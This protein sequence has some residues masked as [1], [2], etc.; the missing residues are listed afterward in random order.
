[1]SEQNKQFIIIDGSSYL[2]RAYYAL[3]PLTNTAGHPTGAMY[4][5]VN[6]IKKL[7]KQYKT[8]KIAIIFDSK[9]KKTS[10]MSYT[11]NTKPI[12]QKCLKNSVCK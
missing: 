11:K 3:P 6:M 8:D 9:Q 2:F 4:G 10:A 5:V 7:L 1:M 12:E